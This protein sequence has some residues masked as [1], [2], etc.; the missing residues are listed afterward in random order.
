MTNI[1]KS[2]R[3]LFAFMATTLLLSL[4]FTLPASASQPKIFSNISY[5]SGSSLTEQTLD[6]YT[7]QEEAGPYPVL[8]FV[9][10]GAWHVGDKKIVT[11]EIARSYTDQGIIVVS[12]NYRL[13][14]EYKHPAHVK[15]LAAASEWIANNIGE[16]GGDVKKMVLVGHSAGAHLIALLATNPLYL[17]THNLPATMFNCVV[18]VDTTNFDLTQPQQGKRAQLIQHYRDE[19]FGKQKGKLVDASPT[20]LVKKGKRYPPF[21][22]YVTAERPE[23]VKETRIFA[24]TLEK[25]GNFARN[26][27]IDK[28]LTHRDMGQA[29]FDPRSKIYKDIMGVFGKRL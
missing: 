5:V 22:L 27:T 23:A 9:H 14:P 21:F 2:F 16:Y 19:T 29:I 6:I 8:I 25:S 17:S 15:D 26:I 20:L 24:T 10:G 28:G 12:L 11:P 7:P 4:T 3:Y 18:P 13:S 1:F